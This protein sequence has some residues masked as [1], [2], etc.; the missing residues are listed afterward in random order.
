MQNFE[1]FS[2]RVRAWFKKQYDKAILHQTTVAMSW[3]LISLLPFFV[4]LNALKGYFLFSIIL[5]IIIFASVFNVWTIKKKNI[6]FPSVTLFIILPM[7]IWF[8]YLSIVDVKLIGLLWSY[9]Y[10]LIF[11]F[12]L[13]LPLGI[14]SN[15]LLIG[16]NVWAASS[17]LPVNIS[18]RYLLSLMVITFCASLLVQIIH[19]QHR[20]L[21]SQSIIDPLTGVF[22]RSTLKNTLSMAIKQYV[23]NQ[24]DSSI[25]IIDIDCFKKINQKYGHQVGDDVIEKTAVFLQKQINYVD[26]TDKHKV[27]RL[28]GEEFLIHLQG[29]N[30]KKALTL[31]ENIRHNLEILPILPD[32]TSITASIGVMCY[33]QPFS[34]TEWINLADNAVHT[35]KSDGR[36]CVR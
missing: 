34:W 23:K 2:E 5:L 16:F 28:G 3:V 26:T 20:V 12:M 32:E 15:I 29:Y 7:V 25:L 8:G 31:A 1:S 13:P 21:R 27:F 22:N 9:P 35:A 10:L 24:I 6:Y 4:V 36:N 30:K 17:I 11:L 33:L 14:F 18:I 19:K